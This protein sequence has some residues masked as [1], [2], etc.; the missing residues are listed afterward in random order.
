MVLA[1]IGS[2]ALIFVGDDLTTIALMLAGIAGL[3]L[4]RA[5][6]IIQDAAL[7]VTE[8]RGLRESEHP[9]PK[10]ELRVVREAA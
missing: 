7:A 5:R 4:L 8:R 9:T 2:A 10:R 3:A 6:P 1:L